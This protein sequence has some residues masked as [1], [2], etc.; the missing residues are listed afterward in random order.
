MQT[1]PPSFGWHSFLEDHGYE[2]SFFD[3][4]VFVFFKYLALQASLSDDSTPFVKSNQYFS[5]IISDF[6][7]H[8]LIIYIHLFN[9]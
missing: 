1:R 8:I 6:P 3:L 7:F 4:F 5:I 9:C 2:I